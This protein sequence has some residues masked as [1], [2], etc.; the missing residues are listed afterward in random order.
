M[1][2]VSTANTENEILLFPIFG[3][4]GKIFSLKKSNHT[5][6][7]HH[8]LFPMKTKIEN[9]QTKHPLSFSIL[10]SLFFSFLLGCM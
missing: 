4:F 8:F 2:L 1:F 3:S 9:N 6:F 7:H 10:F 5:H